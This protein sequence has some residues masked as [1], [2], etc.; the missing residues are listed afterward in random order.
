MPPV[1]YLLCGLTGS[2]KT[3]YAK[4][5]EAARAVRQRLADRNRRSDAAMP[6]MQQPCGT[7]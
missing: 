4:E 6:L 5:L 2:A 3:T 1:V 7:A